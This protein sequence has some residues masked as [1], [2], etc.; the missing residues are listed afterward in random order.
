MADDNP[1]ELRA[2]VLD[3]LARLKARAVVVGGSGGA[4]LGFDNADNV[5]ETSFIDYEWLFR[6]VSVVVHQ[7]GA[8]TAAFCFTSGVPQV[9]VPY[10]LDH[11][12][13]EWR[14]RQL[15]VAPRGVKRHRLTASALAG[16]IR[17][18]VED[19][20]YRLRAAE[21]APTITAEDGLARAA[22]I[23]HDH[24]GLKT[25]ALLEELEV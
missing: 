11:R 18:A 8:G 12:F 22:Q 7:G 6:K 1:S 2:V 9:I 14:M 23:L 10:C 19:P 21:L 4:L 24:F 16:A 3:A 13:W 5:C 17:R 25:H 20:A 15:G